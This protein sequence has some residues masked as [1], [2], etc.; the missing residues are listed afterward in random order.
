MESFDHYERMLINHAVFTSYL[1]TNTSI[2]SEESLFQQVQTIKSQ[3]K[4]LKLDKITKYMQELI[5]RVA[6]KLGSHKI[7]KMLNLIEHQGIKVQMP[8]SEAKIETKYEPIVQDINVEM[9]VALDFNPYRNLLNDISLIKLLSR[10]TGIDYSEKLGFRTEANEDPTYWKQRPL[11]NEL[12]DI[13]AKDVIN[14][15]PI[16]ESIRMLLSPL[17]FR[18]TKY[19]YLSDLILRKSE[20]YVRSIRKY[21]YED[22]TDNNVS[23]F[24]LSNEEFTIYEEILEKEFHVSDV[25]VFPDEKMV[26]INVKN[27]NMGKLIGRQGRNLHEYMLKY[28]FTDIFTIKGA[29][30]KLFIIGGEHNIESIIKSL[31]KSFSINI[32]SIQCQKLMENVLPRIKRIR[33]FISVEDDKN[34]DHCTIKLV[35]SAE[36]IK[37]ARKIIDKYLLDIPKQNQANAQRHKN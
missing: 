11:P 22:I 6:P 8:L 10:Y 17:R 36:Q 21:A 27:G 14:L 25:N 1:Y 32:T 2:I 29:N 37:S 33:C 13:A 26:V 24:I 23:N 20:L 18:D 5:I 31:P 15:I 19:L 4:K 34:K 3:N 7:N 35:G 30:S 28:P 16:Y 9:S 12:I